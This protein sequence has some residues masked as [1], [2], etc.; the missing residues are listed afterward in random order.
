[1]NESSTNK[2]SKSPVATSI[3]LLKRWAAAVKFSE[4]SSGVSPLAELRRLSGQT[5]T[6]SEELVGLGY[7][8]TYIESTS[9]FAGAESAL[10][11]RY[12]D[13]NKEEST[14]HDAFLAVLAARVTT[15]PPH[16]K[17]LPDYEDPQEGPC[18][19]SERRQ[20]M[21]L[22]RLGRQCL[23]SD[24]AGAAKTWRELERLKAKAKGM[25]LVEIPNGR[26]TVR[27]KR[28]ESGQI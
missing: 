24:V 4:E 23:H 14:F 26:R 28:E 20:L 16:P 2:T 5:G 17:A 22:G 8:R 1:M 11:T 18:S 3:Q 21:L 19:E 12:L 7:A 10:R 6:F 27:R 15:D 25:P 9:T 13:R